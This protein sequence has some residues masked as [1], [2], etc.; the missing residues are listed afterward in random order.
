[1][2]WQPLKTK[3]ARFGNET[4][5]KERDCMK[6]HIALMGLVLPMFCA[7]PVAVNS[8]SAAN[9]LRHAERGT[10]QSVD[11]QSDTLTIRDA[12]HGF[13]R[14]YTWNQDTKFVEHPRIFSR[15]RPTAAAEL[16]PGEHVKVFY[17]HEGDQ[18]MAR[19][20]VVTA[21]SHAAPAPKGTGET[22][23]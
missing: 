4:S 19:K 11:M 13:L 23:S 14:N 1:M 3:L 8:A 18:W 12:R 7:G 20:I 9:L 21:K 16:K 2:A 22:K 6:K 17:K 15:S 10:V 5:R